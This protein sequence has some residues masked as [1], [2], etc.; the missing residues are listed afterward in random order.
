MIGQDDAPRGQDGH[1]HPEARGASGATVDGRDGTQGH[2]RRPR[3][4]VHHARD[5]LTTSNRG[6]TQRRHMGAGRG[7]K[8]TDGQAM[9]Q[10][11]RQTPTLK[12]SVTLRATRMA[13]VLDSFATRINAAVPEGSSRVVCWGV[14]D[15]ASVVAKD[16]MRTQLVLSRGICREGS[17]NICTGGKVGEVGGVRAEAHK[18]G[19]TARHERKGCAGTMRFKEATPPPPPNTHTHTP[20]L[21]SSG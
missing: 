6:G 11:P 12:F 13:L 2:R 5:H 8:G 20:H 16:R 4:H 14:T 21:G 1:R 19:Q 9:L 15:T 3:G 7:G 18:H 10:T 17:G